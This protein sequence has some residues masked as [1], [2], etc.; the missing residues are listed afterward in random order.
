MAQPGCFLVR[1]M[2]QAQEDFDVF[3]NNDK[4]VVAVGWSKVNFS[5]SPSPDSVTAQVYDAYYAGRRDVV[6][7]VVGKKKNEARR[8]KALKKDDRILIPYR[9]EIRIA[10]AAGIE[11]YSGK[12]G[13]QRDLANQH[14]VQFKRLPSGEFLSFPRSALSAG[15][16]SRLRVRGATISDLGEFAAEVEKLVHG[17]SYTLTLDRAVQEQKLFFI[18][19]LV[20]LLQD[21]TSALQAGGIGLE[22]L[23]EEL[24]TADGY[25]AAVQSKRRFPELADA[26]IEAIR[27]DRIASVKLLVQVKHHAGMTD[28]WGAQQL[29]KIVETQADLFA[30][31][32][33]VLV[34]SASAT[35]GLLRLCED[36]N[37]VLITGQEL[38]EWIADDWSR[39]SKD[40]RHRL[41]LGD[42]PQIV[43][44]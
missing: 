1:A 7:Q 33:L 35:E 28:A 34:T 5:S 31:Y 32:Q 44:G 23:V 37:I 11:R 17:E 43:A 20:L 24:L 30:E 14:I 41:R 18:R 13:E 4:E 16:Q 9:G 40:T 3:F 2:E 42:V 27:S 6:P 10:I 29:T 8:F 15:L 36:K 21:G 39:L 38:A 19:A 25:A 26:D 22:K 12:D